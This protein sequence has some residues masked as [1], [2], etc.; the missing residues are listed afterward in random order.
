MIAMLL[1]LLTLVVSQGT[2]GAE[3]T[4]A[5]QV[6]NIGAADNFKNNEDTATPIYATLVT[7]TSSYEVLPGL[8]VRDVSFRRKENRVFALVGETGFGKTMIARTI[9]GMLPNGAAA[10]G[11]M[12]RDGQNLLSLGKMEM[13]KQRWQRISMVQQNA[14]AALTPLLSL[15]PHLQLAAPHRW[16]LEDMVALP[17]RVSLRLYPGET[18]GLTG[19][20]GCGKSTLCHLFLGLISPRTGNILYEG[21]S[22]AALKSARCSKPDST[23]Y[24]KPRSSL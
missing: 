14:A 11:K 16:S 17:G 20:N 22:F 24:A 5:F 8:A 10:A 4:R 2:F 18:L 12:L 1:I 6:L 21:K 7:V 23:G 13:R 9:W 19:P 15:K 3:Q